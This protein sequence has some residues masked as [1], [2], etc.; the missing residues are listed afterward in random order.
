VLASEGYPGEY[1]K[2]LP[3]TGV[4]EAEK[5]DDVIVFHAGSTLLD[6]QLVT[7]GGRVLGISAVGDTLD[8]A[9]QKAYTGVA[10]VHFEGKQFRTDIA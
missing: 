1:P 10:S 4:I 8:E 3:I 2:G 5:V 7:H 9:R 6:N